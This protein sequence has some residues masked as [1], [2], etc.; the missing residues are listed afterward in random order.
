[1][2]G[3]EQRSEVERA[4]RLMAMGQMA[5]SLAHEIRNPL[6]SMELYCTLLKK[7]LAAL[8]ESLQL[9]DQIHSG[10]RRLE[11]I[12]SNCLQFS[13]DLI[14]RRVPNVDTRQ[15]LE[16]CV[17]L[18]RAKG[19]ASKVAIRIEERGSAPISV[20]P[21]LV[22][23]AVLNLL[24]NALEALEQASVPFPEISVQSERRPNGDWAIAI[25]DNGPGIPEIHRESIFD[26]F[27]TTKRD[28]TG[29][30]LAIVHSIVTAHGGTVQVE[31][32]PRGGASIHLVFPTEADNG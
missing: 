15:V 31:E 30:G 11:R 16:D 9:A 21:H 2:T 32:G 19:G 1:M 12:I 7:D 20:D 6:G 18:A 5:A 10:I 23:Q 28:G 8:P 4:K 27:V 3:L 17:E 13:R 29:L 22:S 24:L 14:P 25:T 26:P